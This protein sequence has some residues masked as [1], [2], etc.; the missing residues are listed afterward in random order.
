MNRFLSVC[1]LGSAL[2]IPIAQKMR[3]GVTYRSSVVGLLSGTG[4]NC[5]Q[6]LSTNVNSQMLSLTEYYVHNSSRVLSWN[7]RLAG[8]A[9]IDLGGNRSMPDRS[10][11]QPRERKC[12]GVLH[13]FPGGSPKWH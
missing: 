2:L 12:C 8:Q 10:R 11:C 13:F 6:Q 9:C 4:N 5:L 3:T 7:R 1:L